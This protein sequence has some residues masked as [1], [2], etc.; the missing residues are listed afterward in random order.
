MGRDSM[1]KCWYDFCSL[2]LPEPLIQHGRDDMVEMLKTNFKLKEMPEDAE[3][4]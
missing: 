1:G 3:E 2:H 4:L